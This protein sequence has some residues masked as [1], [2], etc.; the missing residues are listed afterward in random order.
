MAGWVGDCVIALGGSRGGAKLREADR[1]ETVIGSFNF[2]GM[3]FI[4]IIA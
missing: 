3:N 2:I 1:V 4:L